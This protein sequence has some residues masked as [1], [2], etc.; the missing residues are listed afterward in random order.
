MNHSLFHY[1][2]R[3]LDRVKLSNQPP[4]NEVSFLS[5]YEFE[6]KGVDI[7]DRFSERDELES[8]CA[9]TSFPSA[10]ISCAFYRNVLWFTTVC[11][12]GFGRG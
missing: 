7:L 1:V 2:K 11:L 9:V 12:L 8:K 3:G 5:K 4:K 10:V 6:P